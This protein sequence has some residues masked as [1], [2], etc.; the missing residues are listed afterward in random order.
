MKIIGTINVGKK[1]FISDPCYEIGTW[2]QSERPCKPG[3]YHVLMELKDDKAW[4]I[5]V[6]R[7]MI[8][9]ETKSRNCKPPIFQKEPIADIGVDAGLAGFY[10]ARYF[11]KTHINKD[12]LDPWYTE[13]VTGHTGIGD[14]N[15]KFCE[16][17]GVFSSSGIGDGSYD[18]YSTKENDAFMI[19]YAV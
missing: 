4:G 7:L 1:I 2:C 18:V 13:F 19:D 16:D 8:V 5:R 12:A 6:N 17:K 3:L 9:H 11:K 10:D 15:Y 14:E